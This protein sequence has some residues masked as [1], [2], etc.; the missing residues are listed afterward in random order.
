[1]NLTMIWRLVAKDLL[2]QR[3]TMAVALGVGAVGIVLLATG[4]EG[5]FYAGAVLLITVIIGAG[6]YFAIGTVVTE[7]TDGTLP[8]VMTL[9]ISLRDYTAA[10]LVANLLLFSVP[11]LHLGLAAL[12]VVLLRDGVPNG[13]VP[14]YAL[15][16]AQLFSGFVLIL[17]VA[18]VSGSL[19][20]AIGATVVGN[21]AFQGFLYWSSRLPGVASTLTTDRVVWDD[22]VIAVLL[23]ECAL[24]AMM[25]GATWVIQSRKTDAT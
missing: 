10:K 15:V 3:R 19:G 18:L 17:A 12:A 14:F 16:L 11:W 24:I 23:A 7:R 13:L 22:A 2:L 5:S 4:G 6:A 21:L 1:M 8:F 9:P 25:L 20:W